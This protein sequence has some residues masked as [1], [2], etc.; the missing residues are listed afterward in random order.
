MSTRMVARGGKT[1][2]FGFFCVILVLSAVLY[3]FHGTQLELDDVRQSVSSCTQQLGSLSSQL[4]EIVEHKLKLEKSLENEKNEHAK[5]KE[6]LNAAIQDEK[7]LRDKQNVDSMNRYNEIERNHAVLQ[8]EEKQLRDE[9][10]KIQLSLDEELNK[11]K[12]LVEE[13]ETAK[14][15]I[16]TLKIKSSSVTPAINPQAIDG[17]TAKSSTPMTSSISKT[18][19]TNESV[20]PINQEANPINQPNMEMSSSSKVQ[21]SAL[22]LNNETSPSQEPQINVNE[23]FKGMAIPPKE[24]AKKENINGGIENDKT[25]Q[26]NE[27]YKLDYEKEQFKEEDE[28]DEDMTDFEARADENQAIPDTV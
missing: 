20:I 24:N 16:I 7:Q 15:K 26:K 10:E 6:E 14:N 23:S 9:L 2:L 5:T 25:K 28:D 17:S 19:S 21:G 11:N 1:R 13:L 22:A 8:E 3:V 4:Q 12:K 27:V 18:T